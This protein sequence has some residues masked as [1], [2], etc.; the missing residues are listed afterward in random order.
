[1]KIFL[2]SLLFF[3][4]SILGQT[5]LRKNQP[6]ATADSIDIRAMVQKQINLALEKRVEPKI[7][8]LPTLKE[9]IEVPAESNN[10]IKE[11]S[12]QAF[13]SFLLNQPIHYQ[14]F[15]ICSFLVLLFFVVRR[16]LAK[17][18]RNS[19][20]VLKANIKMMQEEKIGS[21]EQKPKLAKIR[22]ALREKIEIFKQSE[23]QLSKKAKQLNVAKGELMLAAKMKLLEVEKMQ[24]A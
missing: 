1:M 23:K 6:E 12:N 5:N 7:S 10:V 15:F 11:Q 16:I 2:V 20:N 21:A 3:S 4:I 14:I 8:P 13:F 24:G 9:K 17:V 19:F 18:N 22:K